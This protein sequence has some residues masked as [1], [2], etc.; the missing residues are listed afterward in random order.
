[1][2]WEDALKYVNGLSLAGRNDWRLP[3]IKELESLNNEAIVRPSIP[4][5][6]S[7][8]PRRMCTGRR[9]RGE[10]SGARL[11][12]RFHLRHRELRGQNGKA[13]GARR[14]RRRSGHG[15]DGERRR[16][17][18]SRQGRP[19]RRCGLGDRAP[20]SRLGRAGRLVAADV[21]T[22][23][24]LAVARLRRSRAGRR[25]VGQHHLVHPSV[26]AAVRRPADAAALGGRLLGEHGAVSWSGRSRSMR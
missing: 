15:G 23:D 20:L 1:M 11:D 6:N 19:R 25:S 16:Q 17:A 14:A 12:R 24:D 5:R 26:A 21:A 13:A 18:W 9:H 7:R 22:G 8:A 4:K 3:T 10:S 2:T